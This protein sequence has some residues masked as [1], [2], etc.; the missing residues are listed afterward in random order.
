M[1]M[2]LPSV[3]AGANDPEFGRLIAFARENSLGPDEVARLATHLASS[4]ERFAWP[5]GARISDIASTGGP[6]SLST[7][8]APFLF[9]HLGC[10]V[11]KLAVPGR[12]AGAI[13]SL[14][15]LRGYRCNLSSAEVAQTV[16]RCRFVHFLADRRFAPLDAQLFAY[17]RRVGAIAIAPLAAASLLSKKLAVG[18]TAFGLDL[19]VGPHGNFGA[20]VSEARDNANQFH[21]AAKLLG[22][23]AVVFLSTAARPAQPFIGRGESLIALASLAGLCDSTSTWLEGHASDCRQMVATVAHLQGRQAPAES[24]HSPELL[25]ESI[26]GHLQAQGSSVEALQDRVMQLIAEPKMTF[27]SN[28]AG[29]L[30][31]RLDVIR[32]AILE[33]RKED[34]PGTFT[35]TAGLELLVEPGTLIPADQP[36][37]HVRCHEGGRDTMR[38][39]LAGAFAIGAEPDGVPVDPVETI[40]G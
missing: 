40:H 37:A 26:T 20:T 36:L 38:A 4:G 35:D 5:S 21:E 33:A 27:R 1:T 16:S 24:M 6:A 30:T 17:R 15:T 12:P 18:V 9:A 28:R 22:M 13:D 2:P 39:R 11:V 31:I 32:D 10:T 7:L 19:R 34:A 23:R 29:Y 8:Y 3:S 25:R 14:G